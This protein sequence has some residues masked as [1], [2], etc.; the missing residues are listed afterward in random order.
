VGDVVAVVVDVVEVVACDA[1]MTKWGE[2]DCTPVESFKPRK[3]SWSGV[4]NS[5]GVQMYEFE[6]RPAMWILVN[7]LYVV[8]NAFFKLKDLS[9]NLHF[10]LDSAGHSDAR[11][12]PNAECS[13]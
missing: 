7:I 9:R 3:N 6:T 12:M 10:F 2:N 8:L 13:S 4:A 5:P 1:A 11:L